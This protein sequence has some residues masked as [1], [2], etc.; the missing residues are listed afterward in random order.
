MGRSFVSAED[1]T[2]PGAVASGGDGGV[3]AGS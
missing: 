2:V 1:H 3:G